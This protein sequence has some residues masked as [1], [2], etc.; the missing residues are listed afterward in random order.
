MENVCPT[1]SSGGGS[2]VYIGEWQTVYGISLLSDTLRVT[3]TLGWA[4][5]HYLQLCVSKADGNYNDINIRS[6]GFSSTGF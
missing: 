5:I 4:Q 1:R 2:D 6:F 3:D